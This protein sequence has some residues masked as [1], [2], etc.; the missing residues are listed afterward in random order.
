[1]NLGFGLPALLGG[2]ALVGVPILIHLLNR[3]RFVIVPFA[4]MRFLQDAFAQRRRRL[5]MENL[6]LLLLRCAVVLLAALAMALPFVPEDSPLAGLAG[7]RR[8]LVAIVDRSASMGRLAAPGLTL[9]ERTLATLRR[10]IGQLSDERG[11]AVTLIFAGGGPELPAAIGA[12]PSMALAALERQLP[13]PRGVADLVAA[14]RLVKDRVRPLRPGRLDVLLFSDLQRLSWTDAGGAVGPL[15]AAAFEQGG[16]TLRVVDAAAGL[17]APANTGVLE[18]AS[19]QALLPAQEPLAFTAV[20]RNWSDAARTGVECRFY[21]DDVQRAVQH[22]DLA[23]QGTATAEVRLR[24]DTPGAHHL[25]VAIERD[26]LPFDDGR[27]LAFEVRD[28]IAVL[29]VDGAPGGAESLSGATGYLALALDPEGE[30]RRF[31][32]TVWDGGRLDEGAAQLGGF[33]AIVLANV[34]GLSAAA[35]EALAGAVSGG[36]PLLVFVGDLTEPAFYNERLPQLGLPLPAQIGAMAGDPSGHGGEDYV[37]LALPEGTVGP[38]A[39]FSDP[40]LAVLLQVP[41]FAWRPLEP[42][43]GGRVL[44][45]FADAAGKTVPA[46]VDGRIGRGRVLLVGTAGDA[47]WSLLPRNPALWVPMVHEL[48]SSLLAPDPAETN[49]PVGQAPALVVS[50]LPLSAQLTW[51]SKAV[52]TVERPDIRPAGTGKSRLELG[53]LPLEEAGPYLLEVGTAQGSQRIA[54]AAVPDAREGD[55]RV[56]DQSAL[57]QALAG[58]EWQLGAEDFDEERGPQP[59]DGSLAQALLWALLAAALLESALARWMGARS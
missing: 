50:G 23:P 1:M 6:L 43:E 17:A 38:L 36:T 54:L 53:S 47:S 13:P 5:R 2:L 22:V 12:T 25:G 59:G 15:L 18:L 55:L 44:A 8:E 42:R 51:P 28:H 52:T 31:E 40:R 34:G 35:A 20:V 4:A 10:R 39:L 19:G 16:G 9:D 27:T 21:L 24:V 14:A 46:I 30:T 57:G 26:E 7:G 58:V 32:P 29:L 56:I 45:S 48:L 49:L 3:R 37:T 41:V 33:D 11:D